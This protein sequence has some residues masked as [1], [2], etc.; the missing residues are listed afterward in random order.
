VLALCF[1]GP[2]FELLRL[3]F[4]HELFSHAFLALLVSSYLIWVR[5]DRFTAA[6][7]GV[8][9]PGIAVGLAGFG[10]LAI[11][12]LGIG[13]K[14]GGTI[15][16]LPFQILSFCLFLW[17]GGFLLLGAKMMR[18]GA[19]P[20]LFL[21]FAVPL[22]TVLVDIV[23]T[24]LQHASAETAFRF[25]KLTGIP[26]FREGLMFQ[27]PGIAIEVAK[28]CSGIRSTLVLFITALLAGHFLLRSAWARI[29]LAA[30][31]IPL[32]IV[33]NAFRVLFISVLA[34]Q[35]DPLY[36]DSP[37]HHR[38]G[39]MFFILSLIPFTLTLLWFRKIENRA[40]GLQGSSVKG[41][42]TLRQVGTVGE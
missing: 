12:W 34:V 39:P 6:V 33:R 15:E 40:A 38:G 30:I 9:W 28:E 14:A 36:I 7:E 35:V 8:R 4:R 27:M 11:S 22:P 29:F 25:I 26:V 21:L 37:I 32:G 23:E 2:L 18:A 24:A 1:A 17:S 5:R 3:T 42:N 19:F 10:V 31:V 13:F 20:A 41:R 16:R